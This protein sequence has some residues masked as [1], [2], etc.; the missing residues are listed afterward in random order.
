MSGRTEGGVEGAT[1]QP[2]QR[3]IHSPETPSPFEPLPLTD[4]RIALPL[5]LAFGHAEAAKLADLG[6]AAQALGVAEI[7]PA[8]E[9]MLLLLCPSSEVAEAVSEAAAGLGFVTDADDVRRAIVTCPGLPACA[10][11]RIASREIARELAAVAAEA[12]LSGISVHISGCAKGCARASA[13]DLTVVGGENGAGL[14]VNGTPRAEPL[15]YRSA[16]R[17]ATAIAEVATAFQ[18]GK[19]TREA[20]AL[21]LA[22]SALW[23]PDQPR[24]H[25][26]QGTE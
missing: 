14:V 20:E 19:S 22:L 11:G 12:G 8:P 4:N 3:D 23:R 9:R 21:R 15:A 1:S 5:A 18:A 24:T 25:S 17:L 26:R 13:A 7:R 16:D 10:S 6:A 2:L